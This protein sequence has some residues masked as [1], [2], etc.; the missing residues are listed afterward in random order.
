MRVIAG[1]AKG[2]RLEVPKGL[3]IRP[4]SDRVREALFSIFGP[5]M[6]GARFLD[7]FAGSG[8]NGIEALSRGAATAV[9]VDADRRSLDLV[10]SNLDKAR[11]APCARLLLAP[12]P[13]A[14]ARLDGPF[15]FIFADPPYA[16]DAYEE[17][18]ASVAGRG[19]LADGGR[20]AL[21]HDARTA[22]P[23]TAGEMTRTHERRYGDTALS[24]YA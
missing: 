23:E 22:L 1:S 21:E 19:L 12:L 4:T 9:F 15:D 20:I 17:L 24:V 3:A 7:L 18:L 16:F 14:L 6:D 13:E 2:L 11:L 8:A 10:R 5:A